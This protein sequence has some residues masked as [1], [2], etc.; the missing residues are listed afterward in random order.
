M[1]GMFLVGFLN[2][3]SEAEDSANSEG[4]YRVVLFSKPLCSHCVAAPKD[5][6]NT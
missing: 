3:R 1:D 2:R 5:T 6:D 4:Q